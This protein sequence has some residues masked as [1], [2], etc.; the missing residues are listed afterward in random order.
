M[1]KRS[2]TS[3]ITSL[4][5]VIC[6]LINYP[7]PLQAQDEGISQKD[8]ENYTQILRRRIQEDPLRPVYHFVSSEGNSAP[9]DPNGAL[10]WNGQYHCFFLRQHKKDERERVWYWEHAVSND[11]FHWSL[12]PVGLEVDKES[13]ETMISSGG[14]FVSQDGI[15]HIV[16]HGFKSGMCIAKAKDDD[17]IDWLK[18]NENPVIDDPPEPSIQKAPWDPHIWLEGDH[19]YMLGGGNPAILYKSEDLVN[20]ESLGNFIDQKKRMRNDWEDF[21]CPDFFKLDG[22]YVALGISHNLGV[23]YYVGDFINEKFNHEKYGRMT[24]P[25]GTFFAPETLLDDSGRR[26]LWGWVLDRKGYNP[27]KGWRGTISMPRV[28]T[29]SNSGDLLINPPE[30]VKALRYNY[31]GADPFRIKGGQEQTLND[32]E[33]NSIELQ[34][35]FAG[36]GTGSYGVKVL[37]SPDGR[38]ETVIKYD[39]VNKLLVI[40]F[41]NSEFPGPVRIRSYCMG[42]YQLKTVEEKVSE[43][44]VPFELERGETLK[45]DIF[46]D[47]CIIEVFAN[48]RLCVT[49]MVYPGMRDSKEI[50][51]FCEGGEL[52][53]KNIKCWQMA[54]TNFY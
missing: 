19:Y 47:R 18:F 31:A 35:E 52:E 10:F 28:L 16:Y 15:P 37:C 34:V 44:K 32:I 1:M 33:G 20:W 38:E 2:L 8:L 3:Q 11:L 23:M 6:L 24:W 50:K 51:I 53:V 40:D 12:L 42:Q 9:F 45:L 48:G 30:E 49:Q 43:Q 4:F 54:R 36:E 17:L 27:D 21:N 25:G 5:C 22:K 39:P 7:G 41:I 46:L 29:L 14:A 13:P 26:I